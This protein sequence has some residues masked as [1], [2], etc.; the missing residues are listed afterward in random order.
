MRVFKSIMLVLFVTLTYPAVA[1]DE[2]LTWEVV[3]EGFGVI[4]AIVQ[5]MEDSSRLFVAELSGVI[6]VIEDGEALP[7]PF[8]NVT[9]R[10]TTED[11]GQGLI[12]MA[13]HPD[14]ADNGYVYI[15]YTPP[16][17][18]PILARYTVSSDNPNRALFDSELVILQV[19]HASTWHN[20]GDIA[21]GLD[22]M[23]YWSMGDGAYERSPS[24]NFQSHLGAILRLDVDSAEPY[25]I[26]DDNP[27]VDDETILPELWA[28]GLR[29]PWRISFDRET[30]DLYI[31]DV[32]EHQME[33]INFQAADSAGGEN[34]G[35]NLF[36][37]TWLYLGGSQ[38]GM[39]FPVVEYR[40]G[41]GH[42]SVTGGYVYR[43]EDLPQLE[44]RYVF[45][46]YCS[47][48]I[49]TTYQQESGQWY[50]AQLMDTSY[51]ITTFGVDNAGEIYL[52]DSRNG[53]V[54]RLA[55]GR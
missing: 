15:S 52:G 39:T 24:Q 34:Y 6:W 46:D 21:F 36:E 45:G 29:N 50:T 13:F 38:A 33:E 23:L 10:I 40:L 42:C 53:A 37:G 14:Y 35:W 27:F 2:A 12:G 22:G 30:G 19:D 43:G 11:Y 31:A 18:S 9:E 3:A 55:V 41:E 26:P 16:E 54:Y 4:T 1:Q 44:G 28:K 47:G 32:G 25:A 51:L 49:W 5:P 7:D 8:L 20:G 48:T 17:N